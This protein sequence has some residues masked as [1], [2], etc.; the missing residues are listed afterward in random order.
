MSRPRDD[1]GITDDEDQSYVV[2]V[3]TKEAKEGL[4]IDF[5]LEKQPVQQDMAVNLTLHVDDA[6][7]SLDD[8]TNAGVRSRFW[9]GRGSWAAGAAGVPDGGFV[10][11]NAAV[12]PRGMHACGTA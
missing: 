1:S 3:T 11:W 9:R 5:S 2:T 7:Y 12:S 8:T 6:D 4:P 10:P